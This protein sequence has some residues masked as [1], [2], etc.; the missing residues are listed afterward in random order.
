MSEETDKTVK[1]PAAKKAAPKTKKATTSTT[2]KKAPVKKTTTKASAAKS[3][4]AAKKTTARKTTS[5][6]AKKATA[7]KA[8]NPSEAE[9]VKEEIADAKTSEESKMNEKTASAD[10]TSSNESANDKEDIIETLKDRDWTD[11]LTRGLLMIL[12]G[13]LGWAAL[14]I[15]FAL[16]FVQ[17]IVSIVTEEPNPTLGK[18]ISGV[19]KFLKQVFNFLSFE[20]DEKPFPLS[21]NNPFDGI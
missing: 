13:F 9:E 17:F 6:T 12:F 15:G 8:A 14:V 19:G 10:Q 16:S 18:A 21:D 7:P 4:G 20:T 2:A 5:A 3:T 1:K 11:I